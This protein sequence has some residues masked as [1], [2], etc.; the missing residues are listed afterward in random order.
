MEEQLGVLCGKV[1]GV[2]GTRDGGC[3][4]AARARARDGGV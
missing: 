1:W 3:C 2:S 4:G